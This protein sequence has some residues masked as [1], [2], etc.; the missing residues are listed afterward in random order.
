MLISASIIMPFPTH[1]A[2]K[3]MHAVAALAG[4]HCQLW[5]RQLQQEKPPVTLRE[6]RKI[7]GDSLEPQTAERI[8]IATQGLPDFSFILGKRWD[9]ATLSERTD[10]NRYFLKFLSRIEPFSNET[11]GNYCNLDIA[12][13]QRDPLEDSDIFVELPQPRLFKAVAQTLLPG[14]PNS[15]PITYTLKQDLA[16][17]QIEDI[18]IG[19]VAL[20]KQFSQQFSQLLARGGYS[21]LLTWLINQLEE[22]P[23]KAA[24]NHPG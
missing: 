21:S 20:G 23:G 15:I 3:E 22:P 5:L 17:W 6:Y 2:G 13:M 16:G 7:L 11:R 4:M 18:T 9:V 14:K 1:S 10:F 8:R 12:L 24:P 19:K